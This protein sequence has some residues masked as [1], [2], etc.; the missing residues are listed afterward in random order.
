MSITTG[1]GLKIAYEVVGERSDPAL[2]LIAG[3]G[4]QLV[5]FPPAFR[6]LLATAGHCVVV[7]DNRDV[8][9]SGHLEGKVD[10]GRV[11]RLAAAGLPVDVPYRLRDMAEDVIRLLDHLGVPGAH[12]VGVSMGGEIAQTLA[13]GH[14]ERVLTLT[15]IM[16]TTGAPSVGGMDDIG[17]KALFRPPPPDREGAIAAHLEARRLLATPGAFDEEAERARVT[18][19][20]ER[21]FDPAGAGR[22]LAAIWAG[23]DKTEALGGLTMPVLVIHGTEDH[24]VHVSGGRA[25]ADAIEGSRL[26]EIEGMGHDLPPRHWPRIVEA[27]VAHTS[28]PQARPLHD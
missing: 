17:R 18:E 21:A 15:S 6:K 5:D 1:P 23:P 4:R 13:I 26:L 25:T 9:L 12:V 14:P 10:L 2:V 22:Q 11:R 27:I 8:G 28:R 19:E 20:Y 16:S 24:L 3:L 7:F